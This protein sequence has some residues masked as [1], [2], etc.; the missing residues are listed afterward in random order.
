MVIQ[1]SLYIKREEYI[2]SMLLRISICPDKCAFLHR[3]Y[4]KRKKI[5]TKSI[6]KFKYK[7]KF[8]TRDV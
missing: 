5:K 8:K 3:T 4:I 6:R 2:D 7:E 1:S